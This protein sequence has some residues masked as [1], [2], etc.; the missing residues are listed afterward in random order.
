MESVSWESYKTE[1]KYETCYNP[2]DKQLAGLLA[3]SAAKAGT[4]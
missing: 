2:L 1:Y 3:N 4:F